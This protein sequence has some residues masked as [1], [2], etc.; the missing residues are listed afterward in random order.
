[1]DGPAWSGEVGAADFSVVGGEKSERAS[2]ERLEDPEVAIEGEDA[3][4]IEAGRQDD[5]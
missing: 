1:V 4:G 3:H 2:A 5:D